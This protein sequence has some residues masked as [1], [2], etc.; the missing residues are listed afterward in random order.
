MFTALLVMI[1]AQ[2]GANTLMNTAAGML[3]GAC[4]GTA[5]PAEPVGRS[6]FRLEADTTAGLTSK[7]RAIQEDGTR[8]SVD[9]RICTRKPRTLFRTD[10]TD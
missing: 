8:C 7:D 6:P 3:S 1:A 2:D 5:C 10:F 4:Q 9:A